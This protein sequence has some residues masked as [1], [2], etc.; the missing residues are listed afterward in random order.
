MVRGERVGGVSM[1]EEMMSGGIMSVKMVST[2]RA[3]WGDGQWKTEKS[4]YER[5]KIRK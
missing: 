4:V 2:E 5:W 3:E 1:S